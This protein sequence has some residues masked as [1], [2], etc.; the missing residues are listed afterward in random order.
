LNRSHFFKEAKVQ[1]SLKS[2]Q[3][4]RGAAEFKIQAKLG[5]GQGPSQGVSF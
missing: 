5:E 4:S 1:T 3:Y 2:S